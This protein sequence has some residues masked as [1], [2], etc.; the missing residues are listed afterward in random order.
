M[1]G[2]VD[3]LDPSLSDSSFTNVFH[4]YNLFDGEAHS[5]FSLYGY[6][7][8]AA[9]SLRSPTE[10]SSR[11]RTYHQYQD[12][13][14]NSLPSLPASE[15]SSRPRPYASLGTSN[16]A[17]NGRTFTP[18]STLSIQPGV[19]QL[20]DSGNSRWGHLTSSTRQPYYGFQ[21]YPMPSGAMSSSPG[22]SQLGPPAV[23][24][25]RAPQYLFTGSDVLHAE[26][27]AYSNSDMSG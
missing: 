4:N 9:P 27:Y 22:Y 23:Q 18:S 8:D 20:W 7:Q 17:N 13:A 24:S 26:T 21:D 25:P 2:L 14:P 19:S 10:T 16:M 1:A 12:A 5:Q 11:C 3:N 6:P 15:S